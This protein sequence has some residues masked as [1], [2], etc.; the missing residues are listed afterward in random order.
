MLSWRRAFPAA[1]GWKRWGVKTSSQGLAPVVMR[2]VSSRAA[3][4]EEVIPHFWKPVAT[5]QLGVVAENR[6]I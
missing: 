5:Y 6:P 3:T 1:E 2:S 4:M